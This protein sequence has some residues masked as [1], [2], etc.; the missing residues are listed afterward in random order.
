[1]VVARQRDGLSRQRD[2]RLR[3]HSSGGGVGSPATEASDDD[4]D[5]DT[6]PLKLSTKKSGKKGRGTPSSKTPSA[7]AAKVEDCVDEV[8]EDKDAQDR[9]IFRQLLLNFLTDRARSEPWMAEARQYHLAHWLGDYSDTD[10]LRAHFEDQWAAPPSLEVSRAGAEA[11]TLDTEGTLRVVRSLMVKGRF[12]GSFDSLLANLLAL[13][14]NAAA[15]LRTK[16]R[17]IFIKKVALEFLFL[18]EYYSFP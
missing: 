3:L 11:L 5:V 7:A 6:K 10:G 17:H 9:D 12:V 1:M 16:V 8:E 13:L 15:N 2:I 18:C 14:R 4:S